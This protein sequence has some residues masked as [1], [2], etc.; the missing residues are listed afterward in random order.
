[1]TTFA[2]LALYPLFAIALTV[3]LVSLRLGRRTSVG[4]LLLCGCLALWVVGL[5]LLASFETSGLAERVLPLGMLL[6]GAY[7]H[8][9]IDVAGLRAPRLLFVAYGWGVAVATLGALAPR[10]LYGPSARA[11]GPLFVPIAVASALGTAAC[12]GWLV[13]LARHA[14]GRDRV[15]RAAIALGCLFGALG[16][17]FVVGLRVHGIADV[18][19]AA[20]LL[21]VS[22]LLAAFAVLAGEH[23]RAREVVVQ[24]IAYAVLTALFSAFGLVAFFHVLPRLSPSSSIGWLV[25]VVFF[26]ALPLDPLRVLVVEAIGRTLFA[27]PINVRELTHALEA[28]EVRSDQEQRLAELGRVVSGV[29]HEVRNP[30]SVIAAN[31]KLLE[32][33]GGDPEAL[34]EIHAQVARARRFLDDLLRYGK[35]R[36]LDLAPFDVAQAIA[37]AVSTVTQTMP[38]RVEQT[39]PEGLELVAD[40]HAFTDVLVVLLQNAAIENEAHGGLVRVTASRADRHV[41]IVVD[42]EGPGVPPALE[43]TLFQPFVTGRGR[44]ARRAGTGLGLA[45]ASRW[46]ERHG[47]T[48]RHERP[49]RG[50][51]FVVRWPDGA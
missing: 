42:D 10:L 48:L 19:V 18:H 16:G 25:V 28:S 37:L 38:A 23:G 49:E 26:A 6:A 13:R 30:L 14:R 39:V 22:V 51:R 24:G 21:L 4:L 33:T 12:L 35:P 43:A 50:A 46:V 3:A 32:R 31:A 36:P 5:V 7:V 44:D 41:V 27:R 1:M 20:P 34:A 11:P 8:A 29:A 47:G 40:R 15:R 2:A 17:G 9:A 45:I